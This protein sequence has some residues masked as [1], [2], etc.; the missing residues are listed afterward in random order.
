MVYQLFEEDL[1]Y[2]NS[3]LTYVE[4][5]PDIDCEHYCNMNAAGRK[6]LLNPEAT[7]LDAVEVFQKAI[8]NTDTL[9]GLLRI[10][11]DL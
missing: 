5:D 8:N 3:T 9:F 6:Y 7:K 11:P 2:H 10:R 4:I 1:C